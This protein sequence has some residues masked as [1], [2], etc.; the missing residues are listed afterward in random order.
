MQEE[1]NVQEVQK[2]TSFFLVVNLVKRRL[3]V[4]LALYEKNMHTTAT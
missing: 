2:I 3:S 1:K 4:I